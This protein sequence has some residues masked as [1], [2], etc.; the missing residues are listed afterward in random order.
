MRYN[1]LIA[2]QIFSKL[3]LDLSCKKVKRIYEQCIYTG[4]TAA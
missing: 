4:P 2:D 3:G 1:K